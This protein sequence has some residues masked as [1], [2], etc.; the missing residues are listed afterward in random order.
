MID[1]YI[2]KLYVVSSTTVSKAAESN[3]KKMLKEA[4][5]E[6]SLEIIDVL[7]RPE[8]AVDAGIA[9]TPTLVKESPLPVKKLIGKLDDKQKVLADLG[10]KT[11][12]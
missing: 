11:K 2:L 10:I 12:D 7:E 8:L 1:N 4:G 6:Y 3:L 5:I 9:A